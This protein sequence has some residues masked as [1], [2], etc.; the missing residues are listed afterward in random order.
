MRGTVS[1][2]TGT[3]YS[4]LRCTRYAREFDQVADLRVEGVS[5]SATSRLTGRSRDTVARW[6]ERTSIAAAR[7]TWHMLRDFEFV[8]LQADEL[9]TFIGRKSRPKAKGLGRR[10]QI[11][12]RL[13]DGW[14]C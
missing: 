5:I 1:T 4:G 10:L 8:E 11:L 2:N 3:A 14:G 6:L 7:F 13:R 9:Y 12:T